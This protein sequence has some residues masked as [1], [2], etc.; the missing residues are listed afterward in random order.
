[1][2]GYSRRKKADRKTLAILRAAMVVFGGMIVVLGLLLVILPGFRVKKILVE[3]N[4]FYSA[5]QI[6]QSSGIEVGEELLA[7][8]M[9]AVI[10]KILQ[11]C[12][13]ID[14]IS[15]SSE[16]ITS[17]RITV[18][19]KDDKG[20]MYA[21][22]NGKYVAFDSNFT[23]LEQTWNKEDFSSF[24]EVKLPQIAALSVG[25]KIHFANADT[26]MDYVKELLEKLDDEG[27]LSSVTYI[28]FSQKF[29]VSYVMDGTCRVKLGKVGDLDTKLM[30]VEEI[31]SAKGN[32]DTYAIVDVSS[33]EKPTY[34]AGSETDFLM[35]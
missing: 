29:Q 19:E 5:D 8:D 11:E 3:G 7:L 27:I 33:T 13:R 22:F 10:E 14:S 2:G 26:N 6:I 16:S 4:S 17:I 31:L 30:L 35:K 9:N 12:P 28:D 15:I 32:L 24:I 21:A 18:K 23:V 20:T 1:M 25:G 34:R